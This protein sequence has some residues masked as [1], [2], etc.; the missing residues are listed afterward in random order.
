MA[1]VAGYLGITAAQFYFGAAMVAA[2]TYTA[3]NQP[4]APSFDPIDQ[5]DQLTDKTTVAEE[6]ETK[7]IVLD[8]EDE[9]RKK[10]GIAQF[11]IE[12]EA[13]SAPTETGVQVG[14]KPRTSEKSVTGVQ[15]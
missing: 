11:T 10:K 3:M 4:S 14:T 8:S 1:T 9:E 6:E 13:G 5:F 12:Q 2:S 7:D 15:I